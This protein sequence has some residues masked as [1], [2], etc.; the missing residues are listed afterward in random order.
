MLALARRIYDELVHLTS[1][2]RDRLFDADGANAIYERSSLLPLM[3]NLHTASHH[4]AADFDNNGTAF[5]SQAL[6]LGPGTILF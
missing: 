4:A 3:R 6:G 5:G 1:S 2:R